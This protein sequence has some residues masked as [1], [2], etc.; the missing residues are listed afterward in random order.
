ML[1]SAACRR[2]RITKICR[3]LLHGVVDVIP[4]SKTERCLMLALCCHGSDVNREFPGCVR[5]HAPRPAPPTPHT[6]A[7][8]ARDSKSRLVQ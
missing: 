8:V 6:L 1:E 3:F 7:V 2:F 5:P 4:F